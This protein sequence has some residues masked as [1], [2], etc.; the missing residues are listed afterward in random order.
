MHRPIMTLVPFGVAIAIVLTAG[1]AGVPWAMEREELRN[2]PPQIRNWFESMK[3]PMG[4]LCC[5]YADGHRTEYDMREN[6]YWVPINQ[7][8]T[9]VPPEV[10]IFDKG[11]P[12]TEAVVWYNPVVE[13]GQPTG[14]H[15]ILC[16]VPGGGS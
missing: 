13:N 15:K 2:V 16:F 1:L 9:P 11:N 4:K 5:S 14:E 7:I 10:V 12:F 6:S 8:W 3:S